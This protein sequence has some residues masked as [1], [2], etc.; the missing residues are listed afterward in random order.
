MEAMDFRGSSFMKLL[1]QK[2]EMFS[3]TV[4]FSGTLLQGTFAEK[5]KQKQFPEGINLYDIFPIASGSQ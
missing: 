2:E 5:G 3:A 1:R 4:Y